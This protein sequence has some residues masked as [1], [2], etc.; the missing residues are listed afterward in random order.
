MKNEMKLSSVCF[1]HR[2]P[3]EILLSTLTS[4]C[5]IREGHRRRELKSVSLSKAACCREKLRID[6]DTVPSKQ[7]YTMIY[8]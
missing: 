5:D 4:P 2:I 1:A 3:V 7:D 8:S 6:G